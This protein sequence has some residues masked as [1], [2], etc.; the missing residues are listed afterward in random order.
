LAAEKTEKDTKTPIPA[1]KKKRGAA[2]LRH[3]GGD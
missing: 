2:F 1:L 3:Y